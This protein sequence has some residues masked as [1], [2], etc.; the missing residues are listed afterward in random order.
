MKARV[1]ATGEIVDVIAIGDYVSDNN[2]IVGEYKAN[3]GGF[4]SS[5]DLDFYVDDNI[6]IPDYWERLKQQYAGMAMQ[7]L[8]ERYLKKYR[9]Y[10][11]GYGEMEDDEPRVA[12]RDFANAMAE[13]CDYFA[14]ALVEKLKNNNQ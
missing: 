13:V 9:D 10:C 11:A 1:K 4:Y 6:L 5:Y 12:M 2:Q 14:T 7:G 8:S 3:D